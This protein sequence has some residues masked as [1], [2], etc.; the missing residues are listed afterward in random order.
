MVVVAG[1]VI[2]VLSSDVGVAAKQCVNEGM[3]ILRQMEPN[4][5]V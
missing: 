2:G 1:E 4:F 3:N 5:R